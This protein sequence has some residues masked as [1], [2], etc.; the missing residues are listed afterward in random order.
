LFSATLYRNRCAPPRGDHDEGGSMSLLDKLLGRKP[1]EPEDDSWMTEEQRNAKL[2]WWES[3][4]MDRIVHA[5]SLG[6]WA[7]AIGAALVLTGLL[8]WTLW[9]APVPALTGPISSD[10]T[11]AASFGMVYIVVGVP[12]AIAVVLVIAVFL[13]RIIVAILRDPMHKVYRPLAM[14]LASILVAALLGFF[15]QPVYATIESVY[16][17]VVQTHRLAKTSMFKTQDKPLAPAP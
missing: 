2:A 4:W 16:F 9:N 12:L 5:I 1:A 3:K 8:G 17:K 14:P 15:H 11:R 10:M 6:L 13:F 7:I